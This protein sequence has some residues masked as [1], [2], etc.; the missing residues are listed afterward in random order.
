ML[1]YTQKQEAIT[2]TEAVAKLEA[3]LVRMTQART[4]DRVRARDLAL[5]HEE[6]LNRRAG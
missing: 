5:Q 1:T 4:E 3:E 6:A 2:A